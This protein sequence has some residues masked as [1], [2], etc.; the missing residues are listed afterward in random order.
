MITKGWTGQV[1]FGMEVNCN[2]FTQHVQNNSSFKLFKHEAMLLHS[3][4]VIFS[5]Q[6]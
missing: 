6:K 2:N 5:V 3:V 1:K 4:T